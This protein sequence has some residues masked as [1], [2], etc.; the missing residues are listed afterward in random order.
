VRKEGF[1]EKKVVKQERFFRRKKREGKE[2][3]WKK[4]SESGEKATKGKRGEP[5]QG[6]TPR[7]CCSFIHSRSGLM[8]MQMVG[9]AANTNRSQLFGPQR[10]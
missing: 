9:D 7:C 4:Q 8:L 10:V 2:R 6:A 1:G 5:K 3:N